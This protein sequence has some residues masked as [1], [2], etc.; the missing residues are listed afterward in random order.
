MQTVLQPCPTIDWRLGPADVHVWAAALDVVPAVLDVEGILS[1][2]ELERARRFR[3][4]QPRNRFIAGRSLLR[5][6]L[7]RYLQTDPAKLEFGQG[8]CGKPFLAGAFADNRLNFNLAHS[9]DLA[10]LAMTRAGVIGVDVERIR[11]LSNA[12][13]LVAR[14][15]SARESAAFQN[16]PPE[17]KPVAFFNLWTRKEAWL[18]ATGQGIGHLLKDVEA[19]FL[20]G[21]PVRFL[22]LPGNEQATARWILHALEPAP[23]F[24]AALAISTQATPLRYY[25]WDKK[26]SLQAVIRAVATDENSVW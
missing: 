4:D 22:R 13:H 17:Q 20:P 24:V 19:S 15:F 10:V 12:D 25:Y 8:A 18:K 16:L 9:E 23:G 7:G 21:N 2:A 26:A 3:F 5:R 14:F 11:P 6:L 1:S